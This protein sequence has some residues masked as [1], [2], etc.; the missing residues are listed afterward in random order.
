MDREPGA[1]KRLVEAT[2]QCIET[3][4]IE[5]VTIRKIAEIAGM[6]SAAVNYYFRS[7]EALLD[8]ALAATTENAIGDWERIITDPATE[9][10]E[11]L[12]TIL[13]ELLEGLERFPNLSKAHLHGP[14]TEGNFETVFARRFRAFLVG[15]RDALAPVLPGGAGDLG[16]RLAALFSA[17]MG[18][19]LLGGMFADLPEAAPGRSAVRTAYLEL[20][21]SRFV[22]PALGG[23]GKIE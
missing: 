6:N 15:A 21:L 3:V 9:P 8:R 13:R 11:R 5:S 17:A 12:R 4:G 18:W 22:A 10:V 19:G 23:A 2:I 16:L 14:I 20:L 1:E 7:K